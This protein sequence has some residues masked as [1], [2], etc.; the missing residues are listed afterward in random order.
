MA[1]PAAVIS[2]YVCAV[3]PMAQWVSFLKLSRLYEPISS[4]MKIQ[5]VKGL[6]SESIV[7]IHHTTSRTQISNSLW[8][9]RNKATYFWNSHSLLSRG[10]TCLVLS[11]REIQWKWNACW[12]QRNHGNQHKTK[13]KIMRKQNVKCIKSWKYVA[14]C[15][16]YKEIK[17]APWHTDLLAKLVFAH[18]S[19]YSPFF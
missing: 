2:W 6:S 7:I 3:I 14:C 8:V 19:R 4:H 13:S 16:T 11:Q 1:L 15:Q 12:N 5:E 9:T 10:H 17:L 18:K